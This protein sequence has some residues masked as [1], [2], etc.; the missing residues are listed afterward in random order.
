MGGGGGGGVGGGDGGGGALGGVDGGGVV[1]GGAGGGEGGG[2]W[3]REGGGGGEPAWPRLVPGFCVCDVVVAGGDGDGGALVCDGVDPGNVTTLAG[4][5]GGPPVVLAVA[6]G[7]P[8]REACGFPVAG[9]RE[10]VA[11]SGARCVLAGG[12]TGIADGPTGGSTIRRADPAPPT[13]AAVPMPA[14]ASATA[15]ASAATSRLRDGGDG[16]AAA[17][18]KP[19]AASARAIRSFSSAT[20][21]AG[22]NSR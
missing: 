15:A 7:A 1:G 4:P 5:T 12:A 16:S 17:S 2:V 18:Q 6:V 13:S 3:E 11:G 10:G 21:A 8:A 20:G 9:V 19:I 14:S 22:M